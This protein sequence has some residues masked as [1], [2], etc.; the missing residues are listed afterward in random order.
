MTHFR[1]S[2]TVVVA[3]IALLLIPTIVIAQGSGG[4]K[5]KKERTEQVAPA[6]KQEKRNR[7]SKPATGRE[8]GHQWVDLGLPSGVKWATCNVGASEP[9][10]YGDYFAWGEVNTK[11]EYTERSSKTYNRDTGDI[12]G[13]PTYDA[14]RA[15]WG[16]SWRMPT[17]A[18]CEELLEKCNWTWTTSGG[19]KG[20]KV[21]G[22]NGN[23][24]FLPA[25]GCRYDTSNNSAEISGGYWMST[26]KKEE[27]MAMY[28]M[29]FNDSEQYEDWCQRLQAGVLGLS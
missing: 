5:K 26:P 27:L 4:K 17:K 14:A 10:E 2:L 3:I 9:W 24:I 22:P 8:R 19:K 20:Y 21:V 11:T 7:N 1:K 25:A 12:S 18:E 28:G 16:G 13:N 23:S 29:Y 15:N 6:K